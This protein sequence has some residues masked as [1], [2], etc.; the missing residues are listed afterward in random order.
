[1]DN[2]L[3]SLILSGDL[4]FSEYLLQ[5]IMNNYGITVIN[6]AY[7]S[8]FDDVNKW[9]KHLESKGYDYN[10]WQFFLLNTLL[11]DQSLDK[12]DLAKIHKK[13]IKPFLSYLMMTRFLNNIH[14]IDQMLHKPKPKHGC[15]IHK[16]HLSH[17]LDDIDLFMACARQLTKSYQL[18]HP[19][20]LWLK[21]LPQQNNQ[22]ILELE[23]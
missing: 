13:K 6:M 2:S 21:F 15:L 9:Q 4:P 17:T 19:L 3:L 18:D 7:L 14:T 5:Q 23:P 20:Q 16:S 8:Y 11:Y 1:M 10:H 22:I 12:T